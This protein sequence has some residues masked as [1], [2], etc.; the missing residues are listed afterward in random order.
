[1]YDTGEIPLDIIGSIFI[2]LPKRPWTTECKLHRTVSLTVISPKI[3]VRITMMQVINNIKAEI[4]EEQCDFVK[5]KG[6]EVLFISFE[7]YLNSE[8]TNRDMPIFHWKHKDAKYLVQYEM[9][10]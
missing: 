7:L 6:K 9:M 4:A 3:L 2:S 8:S 1:M 10:R 5:G